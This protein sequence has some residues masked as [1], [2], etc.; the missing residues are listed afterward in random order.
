MARRRTVGYLQLEWTCPNCSTRNR[1]GDKTCVN[2]GAPQ[3]E[4]VQFERAA[5]E[6]L[7]RDE[8]G[9]RAARGAADIHCG[10]CGT[11]NPATAAVCSQCGADLTQG[12]ARAAGRVL[13]PQ[14]VAARLV[15]CSNCGT[16]NAAQNLN[17]SNCGAPLPRAVPAM[18]AISAAAVSA[19][20]PKKPGRWL[21]AAIAA[22][23]LL[24]CAAAA[25]LLFIPTSSV[26]GT[27]RDVYWQ[28]SVPVQELQ[29]VSYSNERG[30]PPADAYDISCDTQSRE[31]CEQ[32]TIDR[33]NGYAEVVEEC[34]TETEQYCDYRRDEWTTLQ[35]YTEE[36]HG[37]S[38]VYAQPGLTSDQRLGEET[39]DYAVYFATEKGEKT[40]SPAEVSEFA[41]F[42]IGSVWMLKLNALGSIVSVAPR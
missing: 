25:S 12:R 33:G 39:V 2:C 9:L 30:S 42:E 24:A 17:C 35:T 4:N 3:P 1:G 22:G 14:T 6:K 29:T 16:D 36:G 27:V 5:E 20:P 19:A 18:P 40:Y 13:A 21:W 26:Q 32:K 31:V 37:F 10:F 23:L 7:I 8:A 15:K 34:R 38:P 11:R 28:T 41:Q